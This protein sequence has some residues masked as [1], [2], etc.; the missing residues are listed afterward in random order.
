VNQLVWTV[1]RFG[2]GLVE[3]EDR[4]PRILTGVRGLEWI[5]LTI[6]SGYAR[7]PS[8]IGA[9]LGWYF[10]RNFF[11]R[12]KSLIPAQGGK[13]DFGG[14]F[15]VTGSFAPWSEK[16]LFSSLAGDLFV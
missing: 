8:T 14:V 7:G 9:E 2:L 16:D 13:V 4:L 6:R 1:L 12:P 5:R 15:V 3:L 11:G 10:G